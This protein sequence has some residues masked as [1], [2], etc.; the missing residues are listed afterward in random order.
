MFRFTAWRAPALGAL[1]GVLYFLAQPPHDLVLLGWIVVV[2]L[3]IAVASASSARQAFVAGLAAGFVASFG[4]YFWIA[5]T[6]HRFWQAPWP[7]ALFLLGLFSVFAQLHMTIFALAAWVLRR[8]LRRAPA[9]LTAAVYVGCEVVVPR[10]F[11]DKLGHSQIDAGPLPFAAALVGTHGL[12][13]VLAWVGL[14]LARVLLP[15]LAAGRDVAPP[16]R[17][18]RG[19]E[20]CTGV[21]AAIALTT[22]GAVRRTGVERTPPER[23]LDVAIVQ[24]NIGDPEEIAALLGSVTAAIDSTVSTYVHATEALGGGVSAP[25]LVVWPETAVPAV[26]RPRIIERLQRAT[27][28]IGADLIFGGYDS[29]RRADGRWRMY[30]AAFHIDAAGSLRGRYAKHKLLLFGEY[31]PLSNRF[32]QLLEILPSPGEFTPGPGPRV[33]E[34][35]GVALTPLICYELLFPGVVRAALR[36]GATTIVNLTNDYWFGRHLEPQQHLALT[37]MCALETGRPIVR[38]TNTGISALIAADGSVRAQSGIWERTTLRGVLPI[39]PMRWTPYARWGELAL[40]VWVGA[41][42]A[43]VWILWGIRRPR[44]DTAAAATAGT[45]GAASGPPSASTL[46]DPD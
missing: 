14:A 18:R 43:M 7:F 16:T 33:F 27:T 25:D 22:W 23:T 38:A 19:A 15:R 26:P 4:G 34:V 30:N 24:S 10:I 29:E 35:E 20:L 11:P 42:C 1:S 28:R 5:D 41:A 6:A 8:G 17:F 36:S 31:V 13:F 37:R 32:P 2:P 3:A 46:A 21:A 44:R 9:A 45:T 39:P 12:T 40:A